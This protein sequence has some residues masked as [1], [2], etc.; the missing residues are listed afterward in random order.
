M[1]I[2]P[3]IRIPGFAGAGGRIARILARA[4]AT[5]ARRARPVPEK[6]TEERDP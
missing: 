1:K 6:V 3:I 4:V 5:R 2:K